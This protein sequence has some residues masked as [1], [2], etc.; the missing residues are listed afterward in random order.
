MLDILPP[1]VQG[2]SD[3]EKVEYLS[4]YIKAL[5]DSINR[6]KTPFDESGKTTRKDIDDGV[7]TV[8]PI[9]YVGSYN[10]VWNVTMSADSGDL[11]DTVNI[12]DIGDGEITYNRNRYFPVGTQLKDRY[13]TTVATVTGS[14]EG[15]STIQVNTTT[16]FYVGGSIRRTSYSNSSQTASETRDVFQIVDSSGTVAA[17]VYLSTVTM[18]GAFVGTQDFLAPAIARIGLGSLSHDPYFY[19]SSRDEADVFVYQ[20]GNYLVVQNASENEAMVSIS[21][22]IL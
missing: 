9:E 16:P 6:L 13:G 2:K 17:Q 18:P 1:D 4:E 21:T 19:W 11:Y 12:T 22:V 7:K 8:S 20:S 3:K 10:Y 15:S 14:Q 5:Y